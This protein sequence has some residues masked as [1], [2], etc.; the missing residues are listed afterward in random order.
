MHSHQNS[1][2]RNSHRVAP[3]GPF[4]GWDISPG[5]VLAWLHQTAGNKAV[6]QLLQQGAPLPPTPQMLGDTL[7]R[8]ANAPSTGGRAPVGSVGTHAGFPYVVYEDEVRV[9]GS[10][11]W[12]NN[13]PGN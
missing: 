9:G 6:G 4:N 11:A 10:V 2:H 3:P 8:Q 5:S 1:Q 12:R 7:Q 13:N